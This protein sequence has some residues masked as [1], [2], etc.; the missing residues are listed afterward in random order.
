MISRSKLKFH[1][2]FQPEWTYIARVL[3]LA[4]DSYCGSKFDISDITG[5][6]TGKQKG[7]VEPHIKYA[8]FMGLICYENDKGCYKLSLTR[9]GQEVFLKDRYLHESLT[10]W[11]CHYGLS[12]RETG[13]PQWSYIVNDGHSGFGQGNSN[14]WHLAKANRI[15]GMD[16]SFEEMFGVV[17]RSY[18]DGCFSD[19]DYV[20]WENEVRYKEHNENR[21][22]LFAYAYV[23][24]DSWKNELPG[25]NE[26]TIFDLDRELV[27]G[28]IFGLN[29]GEIDCVLNMLCDEGLIAVNRQLYPLTIVQIV[30]ME[31]I[32]SRLYDNLL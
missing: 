6:P 14:E 30:D 10:H 32:I 1:E 19:L 26:I 27:F 31:D 9:L 13:A 2:T 28:K 3:E 20:N 4:K 8:Q 22:F 12:R 24:L 23:L 16:I 15:F 11:I 17:R 21:E 7:K 5:I 18:L 29:D 25:K